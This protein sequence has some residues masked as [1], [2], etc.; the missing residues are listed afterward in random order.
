MDQPRT[1]PVHVRA[2]HWVNAA[3]VVV[4]IW[5]GFAMLVADRHFAAYVHLLPAAVWNALQITGHRVQGRA[6]HLGMALVFIANAIV[7]GASS[8]K[9]GTRR[10]LLPTLQR[11]STLR[12]EY[13]GVQRLAYTL[14]MLGGALM[15]ATG[16]ALWFG[17]R[18]PWM[19]AVFGGERIALSI[20]VVT[21]LA[22]IAFVLIHVAQV[23]RAG[24]PTLLAMLA[25]T[26][27]NEP[28]RARRGLAWSAG[29]AACIVAAF[30]IVG[31]TSGPT[32]VPAFLRWAAPTHGVRHGAALRM[33][34][35]NENG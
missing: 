17:R 7:Y 1:H 29:L 34:R 31:R 25:G 33:H 30:A 10:R 28:V 22:L 12:A 14:V 35:H 24:M 26:T 18:A 20:H 23:L 13:N 21:A 16:L 32:G 11:A 15:I 5:S 27:A 9:T 19:L 6:W 4:M 8:L 2:A 3:V